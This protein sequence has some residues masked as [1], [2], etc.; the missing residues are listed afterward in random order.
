MFSKYDEEHDGTL[1]FTQLLR[2]MRGN[3]NAWDFFGVSTRDL[4]D[5]QQHFQALLSIE[6]KF[7][8]TLQTQLD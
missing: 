2:L 4:D 1:T 8:F 3:R 7:N 6:E 5:P